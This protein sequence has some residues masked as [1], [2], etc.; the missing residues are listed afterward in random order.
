[1]QVLKAELHKLFIKRF[2]IIA[3][4]LL[5]VVDTEWTIDCPVVGNGYTLPLGIVITGLRKFQLI[6]ASELSPL[7]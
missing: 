3:V 4:V 2:F 7:S 5:I 1:M 6:I